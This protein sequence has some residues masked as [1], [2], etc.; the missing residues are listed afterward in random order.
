MRQIAV[1]KPKVVVALGAIA[2]KNLLAMNASMS[3]LR[4]RFYDFMPAGAAATIRHGR[5]PNSRSRTIPRF[6]SAIRGRKAKPGKIC[7]W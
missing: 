1:I 4:G 3:E 7:R 2:A 5:E 6:F